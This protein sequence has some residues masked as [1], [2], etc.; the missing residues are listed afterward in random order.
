MVEIAAG[1]DIA[2]H[3]LNAEGAGAVE[4]DVDARVVQRQRRGAV[5]KRDADRA[6]VCG[7]RFGQRTGDVDFCVQD[8]GA[9]VGDGG[10]DGVVGV[11]RGSQRQ[12]GNEIRD[13]DGTVGV[14]DG[15]HEW[16]AG[17]DQRQG[18]GIIAGVEQNRER[19]VGGVED[20]GRAGAQAGGADL[21]FVRRREDHFCVEGLEAD[22]NESAGYGCGRCRLKVAGCKLDEHEGGGE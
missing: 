10:F 20:F 9:V 12:V 19:T 15:D 21:D 13:V 7:Q 14:Q 5:G 4:A 6:R 3:A 18:D 11:V 22:I 8:A 1:A 2:R 17:R 16:P